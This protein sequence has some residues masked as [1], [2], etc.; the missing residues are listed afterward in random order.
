MNA[1]DDIRIRAGVESITDSEAMQ[2]IA[3]CRKWYA[4][5]DTVLVDE[6]T[7]EYAS[8]SAIALPAL[9]R[10]CDKHMDG[11]IAAILAAV[12]AGESV[13]HYNDKTD[14]ILLGY[15]IGSADTQYGKLQL[16][17]SGKTVRFTLE[18]HDGYV[19]LDLSGF[20]TDA[21]RMLTGERSA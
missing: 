9:I 5:T 20:A 12:R 18:A 17:A 6:T 8:P 7:G 19:D 1:V 16:V 4:E 15:S 3:R 14:S 2:V 11:G 13:L 10:G 21:L